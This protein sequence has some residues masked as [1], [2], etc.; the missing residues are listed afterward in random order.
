MTALTPEQVLNLPAMPKAQDA[1]RAMNIGPTNGY[2]LINQ[3]E[4]PIEVIKF[5]RVYRV[6]KTELLAFLGLSEPAA[7]EVQS[8]PA[9]HN[10]GAPG[11][12]PETPSEQSAPTYA[13]K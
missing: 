10:D 13:S 8:A 9:P 3:G 4:F 11:V 12:Q 2:T 1:F 7:A 5:G 6:R